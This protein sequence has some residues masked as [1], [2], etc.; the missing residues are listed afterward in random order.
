MGKRKAPEFVALKDLSNAV[1]IYLHQLD[2]L[3]KE[4]ESTARGRQLAALSNG[5]DMAND[6]ARY[7]GL[8]VNYRT[9]NKDAAV[10][11]LLSPERK[12]RKRG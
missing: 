8:S 4:P 10:R 11:R 2:I 1:L 5:L 9:D 6:R 3:M 12:R 7:F